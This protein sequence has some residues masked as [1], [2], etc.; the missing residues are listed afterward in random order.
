MCLFFFFNFELCDSCFVFKRAISKNQQANMGHVCTHL[1]E[2]L[3]WLHT[4]QWTLDIW[5]KKKYYITSS[6]SLVR[7]LNWESLYKIFFKTKNAVCRLWEEWHKFTLLAAHYIPTNFCFR[8]L[9]PNPTTKYYLSQ[10]RYHITLYP[11]IVLDLNCYQFKLSGNNELDKD[12]FVT[13]TE[14][15]DI[16]EPNISY[17]S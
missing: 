3:C 11:E 4:W 1:N 10:L 9:Y 16:N 8:T 14:L 2:L 6:Y 15:I 13:S 12:R 5:P 17:Y 7:R